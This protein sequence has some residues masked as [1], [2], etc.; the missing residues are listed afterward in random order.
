[1]GGKGSGRPVN[2]KRRERAARLEIAALP[3]LSKT[4]VGVSDRSAPGPGRPPVALNPEGAIFWPIPVCPRRFG[5]VARVE[6]TAGDHLAN[7]PPPWPDGRR[8]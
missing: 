2:H 5:R 6:A 1:M 8:L 7:W 4:R 3:F